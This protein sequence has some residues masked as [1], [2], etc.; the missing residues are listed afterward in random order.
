MADPISGGPGGNTPNPNVENLM[1][2]F[3]DVQK[4]VARGF[5]G[6]SE[7]ARE[8]I[9][10]VRRQLE[11][12]LLPTFRKL[13][14][15]DLVKPSAIAEVM[16][17]F[18]EQEKT[19]TR[20]HQIVGTLE[21]Q[22]AAKTRNTLKQQITDVE[23]YYNE[24][25]RHAIEAAATQEEKHAATRAIE[26]QTRE[27]ISK[28]K[29]Q[30][31][32]EGLDQVKG[33]VGGAGSTLLNLA[34]V[35]S[36][37][38]FA[39]MIA[40]VSTNLFKMGASV[41]QVTGQYSTGVGGYTGLG[42]S[43]ASKALGSFASVGA[44]S[45]SPQDQA[46]ML[47]AI[48]AKA[49]KLVGENLEPMV[50]RLTRLGVDTAEQANLMGRSSAETGSNVE[51][52]VA[53][54][55]AARKATSKFGQGT[56]ESMKQIMDFSK[57]IRG[58]GVDAVTAGQRA[59]DWTFLIQEVG[60]KMGAS[61]DQISELAGSFQGALSG[62]SPSRA[63]GLILATTG[64]MPT[65]LESMGNQVNTTGFAQSIYS[66]LSRGAGKQ[67]QMFVPE[68]FGQVLGMSGMNIQ[69]ARLVKE[70]MQGGHTTMEQLQQR[71]FQSSDA[72]IQDARNALVYIKGPLDIIQRIM[73]EVVEK[74]LPG[75]YTGVDDLA[76]SKVDWSTLRGFFQRDASPAKQGMGSRLDQHDMSKMDR[77]EVRAKSG[78]I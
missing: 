58:T 40:G 54:L 48:Y 9:E 68:A 29:V 27:D 31:R 34:G 32:T 15:M 23:K 39:S 13:S 37:A 77:Q 53:N 20:Y 66:M 21:D 67:N 26:T 19:V 73:Q 10:D 75:I 76:H 47:G 12:Y 22:Q 7:S 18:K 14:S 49:P 16:K 61:K 70:A 33:V 46:Q 5:A 38:A 52:M 56:L 2:R 51:G 74:L 44:G 8:A 24:V 30:S 57:A 35:G 41:G 59:Q 6:T 43:M 62:L 69:T 11:L 45:L 4:E 60:T 72:N 3:Q 78:N 65:S 25:K 63:A 42:E 64:K 71:G 36:L 17:Q 55:E 1:S 50:E 28:L